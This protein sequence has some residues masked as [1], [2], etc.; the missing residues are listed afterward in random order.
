MALVTDPA[1]A[2]S[3]WESDI[4]ELCFFCLEKAY[5]NVLDRD[6][7]IFVEFRIGFHD[8][9]DW[10]HAGFEKK[11][12][13]RIGAAFRSAFVKAVGDCMISLQR[14]QAGYHNVKSTL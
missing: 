14:R 4:V 2:S 1:I 5:L 7:V 9:V 12:R 8:V 11:R 10:V 6:D 3:A 13:E